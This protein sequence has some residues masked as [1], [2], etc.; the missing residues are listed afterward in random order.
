MKFKIYNANV[1]ARNK[2][3]RNK[4]NTMTLTPRSQATDKVFTKRI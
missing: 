2:I 4:F 3:D 1:S